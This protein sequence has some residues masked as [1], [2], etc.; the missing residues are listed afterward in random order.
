MLEKIKTRLLMLI[1]GENMSK[2]QNQGLKILTNR[3]VIIDA[4]D[5]ILGR[6]A[7]EVAKRLLMGDKVDVVNADL[8]II[9]GSKERIKEDYKNKLGT[10]TLGSQKK[11]PKHARRP[12]TYIRRVIRGMLPW[13]KKAKGKIAFGRLRVY[14]GIPSDV[15]PSLIQT[16]PK[17]KK[18]LKPS[19]T[20]GELMKTFGWKNPL[21]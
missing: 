4:S 16:I 21:E 20:V 13:K 14:S 5:L 11:A 6:L 9:S 8:A 12:E 15:N 18:Y 7:S 1:R 10:R 3:K 19:I 17:A 2:N